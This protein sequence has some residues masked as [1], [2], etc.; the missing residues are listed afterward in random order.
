MPTAEERRLRLLG[1]HSSA[2]LQTNSDACSTTEMAVDNNIEE[3]NAGTERKL[4]NRASS[5]C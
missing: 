4:G 2:C 1:S 3:M 5:F